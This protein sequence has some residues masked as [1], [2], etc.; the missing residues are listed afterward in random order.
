MEMDAGVAWMKIDTNV[1]AFCEALG[2]G[3]GIKWHPYNILAFNVST[4]INL[5]NGEH[6]KEILEAND[7]QEGGLVTMRWVKPLN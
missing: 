6:L 3:I 2:P 7:I 5:D 1:K 4:T